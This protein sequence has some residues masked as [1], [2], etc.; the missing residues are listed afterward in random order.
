[1]P[2]EDEID[3]ADDQELVRLFLQQ[4]AGVDDAD[5]DDAA[6]MELYLGR[7]NDSAEYEVL[8]D[9]NHRVTLS[10]GSLTLR[11][12]TRKDIRR[13]EANAEKTGNITGDVMTAT[14]ACVAWWKSDRPIMP[15]DFD[16]VPLK[17]FRRVA[18]ALAG[19]LKKSS[20]HS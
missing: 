3:A 16:P 6:L 5:M 12:L 4:L 15:A 18:A 20:R 11:R 7:S 8:G 1:M 17:E 9:R 2:H 13:V 19:F 10:V 14:S